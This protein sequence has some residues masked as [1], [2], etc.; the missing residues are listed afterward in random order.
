MVT[1]EESDVDGVSVD[2]VIVDVSV[3]VDVESWVEVVE[4]ELDDEDD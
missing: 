3:V 2:V 1:L 4:V